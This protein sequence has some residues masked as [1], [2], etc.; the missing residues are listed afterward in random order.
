MIRTNYSLS[1]MCV[2]ERPNAIFV[3]QDQLLY[4]RQPNDLNN[5][6]SECYCAEPTSLFSVFSILPMVIISDSGDNNMLLKCT[7]SRR[8]KALVRILLFAFAVFFF[9]FAALFLSNAKT[10]SP[11]LFICFFLLIFAFL[12][13]LWPIILYRIIL[14]RFLRFTEAFEKEL[15]LSEK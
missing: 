8:I 3:Q 6:N 14:N 7:I 10:S 11:D 9:I 15:A 12:I 2:D 5:P 1:S 4:K 13:F